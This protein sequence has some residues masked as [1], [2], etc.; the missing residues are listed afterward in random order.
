MGAHN[1]EFD[2]PDGPR[3][4]VIKAFKE[5]RESDRDYNGHQEGYSGDFQTVSDVKIHDK[6]FDSYNEAHEYCLDNAQ[7]WDYVVAVKYKQSISNKQSLPKKIL[8]IKNKIKNEIDML[9]KLKTSIGEEV[10]NAKSKT[11][12]CKNCD[13]KINRKFINKNSLSCPVCRST[14]LSDTNQK[15][16]K[17]KEDRIKSLQDNLKKEES[18][19]LNKNNKLAKL[20]WLVAGWGAS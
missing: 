16:I 14:L 2:I 7:K 13:S 4:D 15:R 17:N 9:Q 20:R 5:Q 6:V 18:N 12:G 10:V 8:D 3:S 11:I 1:I 19:F